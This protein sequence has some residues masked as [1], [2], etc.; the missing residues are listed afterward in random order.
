MHVKVRHLKPL[1]FKLFKGM[2][3]GVMLECGSH[4]VLFALFCTVNGGRAYSLIV[5]LAPARGEINFLRLAVKA[6]GNFCARP[7]QRLFGGLSDGVQ[8]RR[9]TVNLFKIRRHCGNR[10]VVHCGR[11]RI[12]NV[13]QSF[14]QVFLLPVM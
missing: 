13:N 2:Q 4:N 6:G 1:F 3:N 7:V 9:V 5:R 14:C 12:V 8:R 11:R 10:N